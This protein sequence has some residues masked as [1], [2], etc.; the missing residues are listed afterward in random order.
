MN[1]L[2][3]WRRTVKNITHFD[4]EEIKTLKQR[5]KPEILAN[6]EAEKDTYPNSYNYIMDALNGNV[7]VTQLTLE[8]I[9]SITTYSP[10][11]INKITDIYDMFDQ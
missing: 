9:N 8:T 5:L 1:S 4:M 11:Y 2:G 6:I 7:A 10:T 3:S